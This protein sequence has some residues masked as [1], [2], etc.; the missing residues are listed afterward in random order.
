L[1]LTQVLVLG[2]L[3]LLA[4]QAS[5]QSRYPNEIYVWQHVWTPSLHTAID[6]ITPSIAGWRVLVAEAN[7][8]GRLVPVP[9]D[10]AALA[11]TRRPVIAVFRIDGTLSLAGYAPFIS[12]IRALAARW[13][14]G[15][16][17]G[18]E[19]DYDCATARLA[20]YAQFLRALRKAQGLPA[21][22]SVTALPAWLGSDSLQDVIAA[23]DEIVL[24]VHAVRGPR[25][26]LF[27]PRVARAWI[28]RLATLDPKPFRVA[29]PDYGVR[30]I[31]DRR[32]NIV[33]VESESP[34]LIGGASS[35]ELMATPA[36]LSALLR[37]LK[38]SSPP[39]LAGIVWFRLPTDRDDRI[40]SLSTLRA[41]MSGAEPGQAIDAVASTSA[42]AGML[43]VALVNR[44]D[45]DT[46]LPAS[47]LLPPQCGLG[48]G[49]NGYGLAH[50]GG[51][52]S[53][54]RLQ[55]GLLRAHHRLIVG[56]MRCSGGPSEIHVRP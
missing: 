29:L 14:A 54:N 46:P 25:F 31:E 16:A 1:S 11:R 47:L 8:S 5:A 34:R 42:V 2:A 28:D 30:V 4:S 50:E 17:A 36:E 56:W 33:A 13:P 12:Q 20:D 22:L 48:D 40:W 39:H 6:D 9:V 26:G 19:I 35:E 7:A 49:V 24:Q 3:T 55:T 10:R 52:I 21:R 51:K 43:D 27:E 44:G 38:T 15:S 45:M 23:S 41:V 32:E 37:S 18:I 53:L